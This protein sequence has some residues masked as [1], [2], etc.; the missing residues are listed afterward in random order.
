MITPDA[1]TSPLLGAAQIE[2]AVPI[3]KLNGLKQAAIQSN[4]CGVVR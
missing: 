2:L 4:H 3:Q 1:P